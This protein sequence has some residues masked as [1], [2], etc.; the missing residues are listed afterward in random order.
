M[1]KILVIASAGGHLTQAMC[2]TST[3]EH[4]YLVSNKKN[5]HSDKIKRFFKIL[6]TQHNPFIHFVNLFFALYVICIVRPKSILSTGGPIVL[7][8]ALIAKFLP[9]KFIYLDTLSRVVELSNTGKLIKK[10][11]LYDEF[12]TQWASMAHEHN[13]SYMGKCFDILGENE[14]KTKV[15]KRKEDPIILV[16]VGTNQY[17]F[18]RL[19]NLLSEHPLYQD[20]RVRW[21]IQKG[22]NELSCIPPNCEIVD[23]ISR[24][25]METFTKHASLVI[26][27]C[28]IG[29]I[30]LMLSYQKKV[31]FVPRI[32]AENEFSDDHQL[33]IANE[34][35]SD[36]FTILAPNESLP[37]LSYEQLKNN[38]L[39]DK[40]ID[41]T[42]YT[43]A[44]QIKHLVTN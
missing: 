12:F 26:S 37:A 2:A 32:A 39:I 43:F 35:H 36:L 17:K 18:D 20:N 27:H 19:F 33:Q 42:N 10:Y 31:I 23:M 25:K 22:H 4:V 24:D 5:I 13:V 40:P 1:N 34:I 28:G 38:T 14:Y 44:D 16:T 3:C 41:P 21:V 11:K 7:P 30:N 8:F 6:D 29:S 9:I 15:L